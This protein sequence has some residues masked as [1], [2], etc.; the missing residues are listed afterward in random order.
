MAGSSWALVDLPVG[1]RL[2]PGCGRASRQAGDAAVLE[3]IMGSNLEIRHFT[4]G[5]QALRKRV[6]GQR[7][8]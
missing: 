1:I 8:I 2:E 3:A 4:P 5:Q 7:C 6:A